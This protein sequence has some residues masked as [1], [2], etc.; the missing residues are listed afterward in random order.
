MDFVVNVLV[1][2]FAKT[3]E[4]AN[5]IMLKIHI[6]GEGICGV[7]SRDIAQTKVMQVT[8]FA[9]NNEQPLRCVLRE[10]ND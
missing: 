2:F 7:Y 10:I 8:D 6:A 1:Q 5:A 4:S 3:E 9:R